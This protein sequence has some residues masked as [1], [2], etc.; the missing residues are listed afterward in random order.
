MKKRAR[1]WETLEAV[2]EETW[3]M[4]KRG[5]ARYND[6]FHWPALGTTASTPAPART[7]LLRA[8]VMIS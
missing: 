2:I 3:T 5:A 8:P 7:T 1:K 4:L 6:P